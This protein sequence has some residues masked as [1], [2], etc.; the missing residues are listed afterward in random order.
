MAELAARHSQQ[1][2]AWV[3]AAL[4]SL[5]SLRLGRGLDLPDVDSGATLTFSHGAGQIVR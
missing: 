1:K 2:W 4:F 3:L 5:E